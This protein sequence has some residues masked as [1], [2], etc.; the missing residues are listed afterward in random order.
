MA[1]RDCRL[2]ARRDELL[3]LENACRSADDPAR[4]EAELVDV[5][6]RRREAWDSQGAAA[7][8]RRPRAVVETGEDAAEVVMHQ[9]PLIMPMNEATIPRL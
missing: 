1:D 7:A 2:P 3:V 5:H 8:G 6:S 4:V 9:E